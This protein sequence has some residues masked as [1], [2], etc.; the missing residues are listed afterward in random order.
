MNGT[1]FKQ[2]KALIKALAINTFNV[3]AKKLTRKKS[4]KVAGAVGMGFAV[5]FIMAYIAVMSVTMTL[6]A[7]DNGVLYEYLYFVLFLGQTAVLFFGGFAAMN[8]LYFSRDNALL[9]TL[10]I[11]TGTLFAAKFSLTYAAELFFAAIILF[12]MLTTT[13]VVGLIYN[14]GFNWT[15]FLVEIVAILFVPIL[16]LAL[17]TALSMPLMRLVAFFKKRAVGSGI[18]L[19][20]LYTLV[21]VVYFAVIGSFATISADEETGIIT[22]SEEVIN[23]FR[24][25]SK[26][27]IF[28]YPLVNA[29]YCNNTA[30]YTLAYV[31]GSAVVMAA[32]IAVSKLFYRKGMSFTQESGASGA[33][34]RQKAKAAEYTSASVGKAFFMKE[35]RTL[36]KTPMLLMST[37]F[38]MIMGPVLIL[39]VTLISGMNAEEG[40]SFFSSFGV[41]MATYMAF[42]IVA[43][44]NQIALIGFSREGKSLY[45]VKSL[46][47]SVKTLVKAKL[48]FA[49]IVTLVGSVLVTVVFPFATKAYSPSAI[50]GI[51]LITLVGGFG[52]NCLGLKNDL[53]NPNLNWN[54][55]NELTKN[56]RRTLKPV[57]IAVGI[58][59]I[60][61][62]LAVVLSLQTAIVG[63]L[64]YLLYFGICFIPSLILAIVGW[65]SLMNK[66][67]ETFAK[68]GG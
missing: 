17:I 22:L 38:S 27:T 19:A 32:V 35:I 58:G 8:Y 18:V 51:F 64:A 26:A 68:I 6:A 16:P 1:A 9:S 24:G 20:I 4:A 3:G 61:I 13:G 36:V 15:Y 52:M 43:G 37:I 41:G 5:F 67:E 49:T 25:I 30:L 47:I 66:P 48:L 7:Y 60:Y 28:N 44:T 31:G 10:P 45:L 63:E 54:N 11:G 23:A 40:D 12:P 34:K 59:I 62:V 46:P 39:F 33:S 65:N 29:L 21:F 42:I 56:N 14:L 55:I 2:Y 53:K 50:I 57:L